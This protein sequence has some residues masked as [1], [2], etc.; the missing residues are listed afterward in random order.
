MDEASEQSE[1]EI[2]VRLVER[3]HEGDEAAEAEFF[4]RYERGLLLYLR[5]MCRDH[6]LAEDLRQEAFKIVLLRLRESG[7]KDPSRLAAFLRRTAR[8]LFIGDYRKKAR[9]RTENGV[10]GLDRLATAPA[11]QLRRLEKEQQARWV[12]KL[13]GQLNTPRDRELLYRFYI[14]E[15]EKE[16]ICHDLDLD[17][18]HFNRVLFRARQRFKQIVEKSRQGRQSRE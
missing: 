3:V 17:S 7:L 5:T 1:K 4:R 9:R 13:I 16:D 6:S 2:A 14:A 8:N 12:R 18:L 15:E 11:E 10:Q